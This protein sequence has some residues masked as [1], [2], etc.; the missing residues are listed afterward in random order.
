MMVDQGELE[1]IIQA[2]QKKDYIKAFMLAQQSHEKYPNDPKFVRILYELSMIQN[3]FQESLKFTERMNQD[4]I[5]TAFFKLISNIIIGD[6]EEINSIVNKILV[7]LDL[8]AV[9]PGRINLFYIFEVYQKCM[10][11]I[12]DPVWREFIEIVWRTLDHDH[13]AQYPEYWLVKK[14][15]I[16]DDG[17]YENVY[18]LLPGL[19]PP[20]KIEDLLTKRIIID[21]DNASENNL[22]NVY[23]KWDTNSSSISLCLQD[24]TLCDLDID[25]QKLNELIL[26]QW[27]FAGFF[28]F[29]G[30]GNIPR[31]Q[32]TILF[33]RES[34]RR[35]IYGKEDIQLKLISIDEKFRIEYNQKEMVPACKNCDGVLLSEGGYRVATIA[36][37]D[38]PQCPYC[39]KNLEYYW[40]SPKIHEVELE[41]NLQSWLV[42]KKRHNIIVRHKGIC[43]PAFFQYDGESVPYILKYIA[44]TRDKPIGPL[45]ISILNEWHHP[46]VHRVGAIESRNEIMPGNFIPVLREDLNPELLYDPSLSMSERISN[47]N[48]IFEKEIRKQELTRKR[49]D[50]IRKAK[51]ETKIKLKEESVDL[52]NL[53]LTS[54]VF[55]ARK[56]LS[57]VY[58]R[59]ARTKRRIEKA[60][61]FAKFCDESGNLIEVPAIFK[62]GAS[63]STQVSELAFTESSL[64]KIIGIIQTNAYKYFSE[65]KLFALESTVQYQSGP[66]HYYL[67]AVLNSPSIP[68]KI[69]KQPRKVK[70]C[71]SC[72]TMLLRYSFN[73][74]MQRD[75]LAEKTCPYCNNS[76]EIVER[77]PKLV[78]VFIDFNAKDCIIRGTN[79]QVGV[80][81]NGIP[82]KMTVKVQSLFHILENYEMLFDIKVIGPFNIHINNLYGRFNID[83]INAK[84]L[85]K[86]IEWRPVVLYPEDLIAF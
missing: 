11:A 19:N 61:F 12:Q 5:L 35:N 56:T 32:H 23:L 76:L 71:K 41:T 60:L 79:N 70:A 80:L 55:D 53:L 39:N 78:P 43:R 57:G 36:E 69:P 44:L 82:I 65:V 33:V 31:F 15:Y 84:I 62:A 6:E 45:I 59:M 38:L 75:D 13:K 52:N 2:G 4:D 86:E 49:N 67:K 37:L 14:G 42:M 29:M 40:R 73:W 16:P 46:R 22:A 68:T 9:K 25:G 26:D 83:D 47:A 30:K 10:K 64:E 7:L 85:P 51:R 18:F 63:A 74:N 77:K 58:L 24:G 8:G 54:Q 50:K 27:N 3:N 1:K 17:I 20:P 81:Y 48:K 28:Y 72:D 34:G 66:I 21:I